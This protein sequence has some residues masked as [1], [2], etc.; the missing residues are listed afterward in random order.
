MSVRISEVARHVRPRQLLIL[1]VR[2][3]QV[4]LSPLLPAACR[5]HPSCSNY[6]IDALARHGA[7][8]GSWLAAR[9]ILRCNPFSAG[10]FDPVP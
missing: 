3:Y 1:A 5:Y 8:K 6:A 10:G 7:L 9:R 2:G 4:S